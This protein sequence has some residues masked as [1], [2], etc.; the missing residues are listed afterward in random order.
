MEDFL[1]VTFDCCSSDAATLSV[2]RREGD[3]IRVLNIIHGDEAVKVYN[4]LR[5]IEAYAKYNSV[6][7]YV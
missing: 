4:K 5:G 3:K 6:G 1:M 2:A 7:V